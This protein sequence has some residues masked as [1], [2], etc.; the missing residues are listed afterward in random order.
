VSFDGQTFASAVEYRED[1]TPKITS[2]SPE[3]GSAIGGTEVQIQGTGFSS[4]IADVTVTI[5]GVDCDVQSSTSTTITCLTGPGPALN[6]RSTTGVDNVVVSIANN[7]HAANPNHLSFL[8]IELWSDRFTWGCGNVPI[9][10]DLIYVPAG[11]NLFVDDDR[12]NSMNFA[13]VVV[14]GGLF[15]DD[16]VEI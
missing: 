16:S 8:Y 14:Q 9:D 10:G 15:F 1:L 7:G 13:G 5:D 2:L 11:L 4:N 12:I 6:L 3:R